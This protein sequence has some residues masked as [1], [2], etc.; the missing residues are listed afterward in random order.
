[1][2]NS[3]KKPTK[4]QPTRSFREKDQNDEKKLSK[5]KSFSFQPLIEWAGCLSYLYPRQ[6]IGR[7]AFEKKLQIEEF[8]FLSVIIL[9]YYLSIL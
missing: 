8:L 3:N 7:Y 4:Q 5:G 1:M 9:Q 2:Q 6:N